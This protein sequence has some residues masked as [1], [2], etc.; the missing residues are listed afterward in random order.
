MANT[1]F[2]QHLKDLIK[3]KLSQIICVI[4]V[5]IEARQPKEMF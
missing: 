1:I 5:K 4:H 3:G 2:I